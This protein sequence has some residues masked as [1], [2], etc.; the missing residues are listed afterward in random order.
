MRPIAPVD[1][2]LLAIV[3]FAAA[4]LVICSSVE[5]DAIWPIMSLSCI[6]FIGSWC[7]SWATMSFRK[8][9][10]PSVPPVL[11]ENSVGVGVGVVELIDVVSVIREWGRGSGEDVHEQPAGQLDRRV[12]RGSRLGVLVG[13]AAGRAARR[14]S[15][16]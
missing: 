4:M 6:G 16:G 1:D 5:N 12:G 11:R 13:V 9:S 3:W 15:A 8:S 7:W 10:L 14:G 2:R